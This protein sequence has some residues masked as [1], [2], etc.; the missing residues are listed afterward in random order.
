MARYTDQPL[1]H[2]YAPQGLRRKTS[3]LD[4]H[5]KR[6]RMRWKRRAE[7]DRPLGAR[8]KR[9]TTLRVKAEDDRGHLVFFKTR[10]KLTTTTVRRLLARGGLYARRISI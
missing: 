2:R 7:Q 6:L 3:S 9:K 8:V 10:T 4:R 5:K 1:A